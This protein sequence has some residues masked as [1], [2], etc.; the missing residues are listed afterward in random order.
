MPLFYYTTKNFEK[1][2]SYYG[3]NGISL[4]KRI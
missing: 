2:E 3:S 4:K 1:L